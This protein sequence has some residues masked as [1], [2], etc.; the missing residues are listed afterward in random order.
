LKKA[1]LA[2]CP[3]GIEHDPEKHAPG[4]SPTGG[5]RF[6]EKIMLH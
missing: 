1:L 6:S 5:S 4:P 2:G 3:G